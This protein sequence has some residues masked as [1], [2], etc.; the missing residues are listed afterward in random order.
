M[1]VKTRA[2][3]KREFIVLEH[4][5]FLDNPY[6]SALKLGCDIIKFDFLW[7]L[8]GQKSQSNMKIFF[9]VASFLKLKKIRSLLVD[10]DLPAKSQ[11]SPFTDVANT[12]LQQ[13]RLV[14]SPNV[15]VPL[16]FWNTMLPMAESTRMCP[17]YDH[18]FYS[19][20]TPSPPPSTPEERAINS[21][22]QSH[23]SRLEERDLLQQELDKLV[24]LPLCTILEG[25]VLWYLKIENSLW[26]SYLISSFEAKKTRRRIS[27]PRKRNEK[28]N[29]ISVTVILQLLQNRISQIRKLR[30]F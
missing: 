24:N 4:R 20:S 10:L 6:K 7:P 25:R 23:N 3:R 18:D 30:N 16:D 11:E 2:Q 28:N 14:S 22:S 1:P 5:E 13:T 27:P 9:V 26:F 15:S 19:D 17:S 8:D 21:T 29:S 12:E